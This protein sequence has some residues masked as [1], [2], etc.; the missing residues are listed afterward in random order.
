MIHTSALSAIGVSGNASLTLRLRG[1]TGVLLGILDALLLVSDPI[2]NSG[3]C[4]IPM[5]A[6]KLRREEGTGRNYVHLV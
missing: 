2:S 5:L 4:L 1:G 6:R 3:L